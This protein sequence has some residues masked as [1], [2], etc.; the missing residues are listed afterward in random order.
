MKPF[1]LLAVA[2]AILCCC[3]SGR[4][5]SRSTGAQPERGET[6]AQNSPAPP[7]ESAQ[8]ESAPPNKHQVSVKFDYDFSKNPPC[9]VKESST[10]SS[11]AASKSPSAADSK[12][13]PPVCVKQFDVSGG[14]FKLFSIPVPPD[15]KG[16]MKGI[17][18]TSP[19]RVFEPGTH[20][21]AV[22][23][24]S[25]LGHESSP[26]VCKTTVQVPAAMAAEPAAAS[27]P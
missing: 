18:G 23:A 24:E 25:D 12:A 16:L 3:G 1:A 22:T 14:K 21:I 2:L 5:G 15:A 17:S 4:A 27:K 10:A 8:Q 13:A 20:F 9:P 7:T 11:K 19:P 6:G 26:Y